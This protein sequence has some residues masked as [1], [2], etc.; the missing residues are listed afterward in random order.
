MANPESAV[1]LAKLF[2]SEP[3]SH[4][5][6]WNGLWKD[7]YTPWDQ[8]ISNPALLDAIT[9]HPELFPSAIL[10]EGKRRRALVPGC[11]R[12]YDVPVLAELGYDAWGLEGSVDAVDAC[13][14]ATKGKEHV[15]FVQ[16]DF[17]GTEWEAECVGGEFD[18]IYDY[19]FFC[20]LPPVK[21]PAWALKMS[22]LLAKN[23]RLICLEFPTTKPP[24]TGGPPWGITAEL[25]LEIFRHPGQD[26]T[27]DDQGF[28]V[29]SEEGE[30]KEAMQRIGHWKAERTLSYGTGKDWI[31]VWEHSF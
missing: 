4:I 6:K 15:G 29:G 1:Y 11:G 30:S 31:S 16:G 21:R 3:S 5:E 13:R 9:N 25:Y 12:G 24:S 23:G 22:Q 14:K 27:Y 18:L 8:G 20:A 10:G 26:I 7:S 19:T 17:F 28:V 2:S